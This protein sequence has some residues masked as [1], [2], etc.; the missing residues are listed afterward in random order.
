MQNQYIKEIWSKGNIK[1]E[2]FPGTDEKPGQF[3]HYI[4]SRT[5]EKEK[6]LMESE[7]NEMRNL[8][9]KDR[10]FLEM[11]ALEVSRDLEHRGYKKTGYEVIE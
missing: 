9:L 11:F 5:S 1:C 10:G 4:R 8:F 3:W 7:A 6:L 2:I